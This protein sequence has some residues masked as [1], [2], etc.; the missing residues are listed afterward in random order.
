MMFDDQSG[1]AVDQNEEVSRTRA[2]HELK[3]GIPRLIK[4]FTEHQCALDLNW[5]R[6][7]CEAKEII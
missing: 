3:D 4:T 7:R 6:D 2:Q 1:S 5:V